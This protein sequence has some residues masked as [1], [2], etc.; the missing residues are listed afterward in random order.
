MTTL[1]IGLAVTCLIYKKDNQYVVIYYAV[2]L[3]LFCAHNAL[4][5]IGLI[6]IIKKNSVSV[7]N[8]NEIVV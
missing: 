4:C 6:C 5:N 3:I 2:I 7:I 8:N 1:L